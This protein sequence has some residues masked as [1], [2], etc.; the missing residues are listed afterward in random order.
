MTTAALVLAAG[1]SRRLGRPKQLVR[2]HGE[3]LLDRA[4]RVGGEAGLTPVVVVLG[5]A[6]KLV[7]EGCDL[8][9]AW[10]VVNAGWA[11][12]MGSSIKAGMEL[13]REFSEVDG[14]VVMTCDMPGVAAEHLRQL[15][16]EPDVVMASAYDGRRGVP[17]YF[18]RAA[19]AEL[20]GLS[21]DAGARQMLRTAQVVELVGGEV[22]VDTMADVERLRGLLPG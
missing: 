4:V 15:A 19:F 6:A 21:G 22:D 14:V 8:R 16:A 18:P 17:A 20:L 5:A 10:V 13:V 9:S 2:L 12:G 11:D 3:T 7:A 1:A